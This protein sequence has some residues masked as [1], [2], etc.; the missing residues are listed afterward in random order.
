MLPL[1]VLLATPAFADV[2]T[3]APTGGIA[4]STLY[5]GQQ[6]LAAC[7]QNL[8]LCRGYIA[9]VV[10]STETFSVSS[11]QQHWCSAMQ[12]TDAEMSAVVIKYFTDNP[13]KMAQS[14]QSLV[15]QA[16]TAAYCP[17]Q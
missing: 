17:G 5:S 6:L 4:V 9:G 13:D 12:A 11:R 7:T 3:T 14:A 8:V 16:L 1:F 10:D 15:T 2:S